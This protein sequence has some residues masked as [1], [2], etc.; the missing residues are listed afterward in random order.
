MPS[1]IVAVIEYFGANTHFA[2]FSKGIL[3]TRDILYFISLI[4]IFSLF[5]PSCDAGKN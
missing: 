2:N 4:S 3:D 1:E 5:H